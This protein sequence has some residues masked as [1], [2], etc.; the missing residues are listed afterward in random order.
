MKYLL[1][2]I[3]LCLAACHPSRRELPQ[4]EEGEHTL[5]VRID[6]PPMLSKIL[7]PDE[8]KAVQDINLFF[9]HNTAGIARHLYASS[10]TDCLR[11]SLPAGDYTLYAIANA[12]M[13]MGEMTQEKVKSSSITIAAASDLEKNGTLMMTAQKQVA[14]SRD[15]SIDLS[16]TR[17]SARI[18]LQIAPSPQLAGRLQIL[19]VQLQSLP[20]EGKLFADNRPLGVSQ[21]IDYPPVKV[22]AAS[23]EAV[24]Y[25][26]ENAQGENASI[27]DPRHKTKD[28]APARATWVHIQALLEGKKTD[29]CLYLGENATSSFDI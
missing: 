1:I 23:Y 18:H 19:S 21:M 4:G 14:V 25:M 8:E 3:T 2:A 5:W 13:D 15:G 22:N 29:Y 17:Q 12:G 9:F 16:L 24:L 6:C 26:L 10:S 11:V 28:Q 27:A 20:R 7:S